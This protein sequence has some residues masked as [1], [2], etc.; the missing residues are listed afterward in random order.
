MIG[1]PATGSRGTGS[2]VIGSLVT[3]L[4]ETGSCVTSKGMLRLHHMHFGSMLWVFSI[5]FV[6]FCQFSFTTSPTN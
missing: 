2:C 5:R 3:E 1:S 4:D 6:P